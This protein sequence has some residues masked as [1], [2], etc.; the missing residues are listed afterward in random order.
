VAAASA[1]QGPQPTLQAAD[2][3]QNGRPASD[4]IA[5]STDETGVS[6]RFVDVQR[7]ATETIAASE[8]GEARLEAPAA[9]TDTIAR[10]P[11]NDLP[12]TEAPQDP[13]STTG[14]VGDQIAAQLRADPGTASQRIVIRLDPPELGRVSVTLRET[15]GHVAGELKFS[16]PDALAQARLETP[17]LIRQLADGGVR[18]RQLDMSLESDGLQ[19]QPDWTGRQDA[20]QDPHGWGDFLGEAA[21]AFVAAEEYTEDPVTASTGDLSGEGSAINLKV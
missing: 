2:A 21:E 5:S 11:S 3:P 13:Q 1:P 12:R 6:V 19:Q 18:I 20:Q 10:T 4:T 14:S 15:D 16:D 9:P 8:P 17:A 7:K